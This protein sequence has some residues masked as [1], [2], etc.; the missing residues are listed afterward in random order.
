MTKPIVAIKILEEGDELIV[1][2]FTAN[3]KNR[4]LAW[5]FTIHKTGKDTIPARVQEMEAARKERNAA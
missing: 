1:S 3:M 4:K 5:T 2:G